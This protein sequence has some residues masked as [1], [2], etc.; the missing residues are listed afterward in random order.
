MFNKFGIHFTITS[1]IVATAFGIAATPADATQFAPAAAK[2][3]IARSATIPKSKS[4]SPSPPA[5]SGKKKLAPLHIPFGNAKYAALK[6]RAAAAAQPRALVGAINA[7]APTTYGTIAAKCDTNPTTEVGGNLWTPS[8]IH[9]A[10]GFAYAV[11]V[12]NQVIGV[13]NKNNCAELYV[14]DIPTFLNVPSGTYTTDP[15]VLYDAA[16]NRF[17]MTVESF[18]FSNNDQ[19][20][21]VAV[22]KDGSG[23]NWWVYALPLS[24]GTNVFCKQAANSFWDFPNAGLNIDRIFVNANDFPSSGS[25][26]GAILSWQ[27]TPMLLGQTTT[28]TCFKNLLTNIAPPI[29]LDAG[30]NTI[31]LS[32]GGVGGG[33]ALYRYQLTTNSGSPTNDVLTLLNNVTVPTWSIPPNAPQPNGVYLDTLDGRFQSASIQSR[34]ALWNVHTVDLVG[35]AT[36]RLYK[37]PAANSSTT[38]FM[39]IDLYTTATDNTFNGSVA[40]GSGLGNAPIFVT[41]TRT[42]T[43]APAGRAAHLVFSGLNSVSTRSLWS[44]NVVTTSGA[45]YS[46]SD[47]SGAC[48]WGDYSSTQV[49]PLASGEAWSFNQRIMGSSQWSWGTEGSG[50][51][52]KLPAAPVSQ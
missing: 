33:S 28:V 7:N 35:Y 39:Y 13:Y 17:V 25:P 38:P 20:Q 10:V 5:V 41:G 47:C 22:S 52:L 18:N 46:G 24:Q 30:R 43:T 37:L 27:K 21:Y 29:V 14:V 34:G 3:L 16:R 8:D 44:Y 50:V 15:R 9:G 19:T 4:L 31:H 2:K 6:Q 51:W 11:V 48:R 12:T 40:T 36:L 32:D 42:D 45:Q 23:I 1:L 49:D 26:T